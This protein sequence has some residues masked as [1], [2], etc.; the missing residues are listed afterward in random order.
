[1]D[2]ISTVESEKKHLTN[3]LSMASRREGKPKAKRPRLRKSGSVSSDR[4]A[5]I[6][7][8]FKAVSELDRLKYALKN[9]PDDVIIRK[10]RQS[11]D[12]SEKRLPSF[13][14]VFDKQL[15]PP[16]VKV[17]SK[18]ARCK[19]DFDP[20]YNPKKSC[21]IFHDTDNWDYQGKYY[22]RRKGLR[23]CW[24]CEKCKK[25]WEL[26]GLDDDFSDE[27]DAICYKGRHT[28]D[29]EAIEE[30]DSSGSSSECEVSAKCEV[31]A[32]ETDS[33]MYSDDMPFPLYSFNSDVDSDSESD[34]ETSR[35]W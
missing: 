15:F 18:C 11:V 10:I 24:S 22:S 23:Y 12:A 1:M 2:G 19:E 21:K 9:T 7:K 3:K 4:G 16:P 14:A 28:V 34:S 33:S 17:L 27:D 31:S 6:S 32:S 35:F 5:S 20:N 8:S 29:L 26:S 25:R 30:S 13:S